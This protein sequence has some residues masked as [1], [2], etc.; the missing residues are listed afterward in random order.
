MYYQKTLILCLKKSHF[1]VLES[2]FKG[3]KGIVYLAG[4]RI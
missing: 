4:E 2:H 1:E 3:L